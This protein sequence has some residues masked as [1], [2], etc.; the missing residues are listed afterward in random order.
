MQA[1]DVEEARLAQHYSIRLIE[2]W[3]RERKIQFCRSEKVVAK[4]NGKYRTTK[5]E[6]AKV[7]VAKFRAKKRAAR[8]ASGAKAQS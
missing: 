7:A 5:V 8:K 6:R 4:A 3:T 1:L 2:N